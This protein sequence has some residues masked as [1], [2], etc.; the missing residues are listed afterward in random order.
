VPI[1]SRL[2]EILGRPDPA[3][4]HINGE[5]RFWLGWAQKVA[6]DHAAAQETWRQARRELELL[7]KE[8]PDNYSLIEDLALT[9]MGLGDKIVALALS[10]RAL[11]VN[12]IERDAVR[13]PFAIEDSRG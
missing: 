10:E 9:N 7:L 8:Q 11:A 12:P 5:L 6:G 1:I 3:L 4:G 2:K 13:G